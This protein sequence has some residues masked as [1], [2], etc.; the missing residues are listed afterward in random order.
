M[1]TRTTPSSPRPVR[2]QPVQERSAAPRATFVAVLAAL[3]IA[4]S[5]WIGYAVGKPDG[6]AEGSIEAIAAQLSAEQKEQASAQAKE[7][8][9]TVSAAQKDYLPLLREIAAVLPVGGGDPS[10]ADAATL[11]KW[12]QEAS[13]LAEGFAAEPNGTTGYNVA[14]E[15]FS[16]ASR[17]F[18]LALRTY[19]AGAAATGAE[20]DGLAALAVEQRDAAARL[21]S[22]G[23]QQL[24]LVTIDAGLGHQHFFLPAS[25]SEAD[26][27]NEMRE[28]DAPAGDG[29]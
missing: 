22:A 21:W 6:P 11:D 28:V 4:M 3:V 14:Y 24:D 8:L 19:A 5:A 20:R 7:L 25:G 18:D 13:R 27:T 17:Q 26:I 2:P 1:A 16:S 29:E 10:W 9:D 12:R 23:A 15:A